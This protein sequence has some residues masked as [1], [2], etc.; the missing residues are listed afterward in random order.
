[1]LNSNKLTAHSVVFATVLLLGLLFAA[2][3]GDSVAAGRY[4]YLAAFVFI[5]AGFPLLLK[6]GTNIWILPLLGIA[7]T[8]RSPLIPLPFHVGELLTMAGLLGFGLQVVMRRVKLQ[9]AWQLVDYLAVANICWLVVTYIKNPVGIA[10]LGSDMVGGRKY[11]SLFFAFFGYYIL[12]R[13]RLP[14]SWAYRLPIILAITWALPHG[15]EAVAL[16]SPELGSIISKFYAI[17]YVDQG[18]AEQSSSLGAESRVLGLEK[19]TLPLFLA[20]CAYYPPIT[21]LSPMNP[22]RAVGF[23]C[24]LILTGLA[25]YRTYILAII[26]YI[27]VNLWLRRRLHD[28]IPFAAIAILGVFV[29]AGA[30]QSGMEVPLTVQRALAFLPLDWDTEAANNAQSTTDWR[31]NMWR[32]AWNDPNYF[33]D[34]V[35]GDGFGYTYQEMI[36]FAN[37]M[38]GLQG[39]TTGATYEM[40]IIR[41]SL[42]NGPLSSLRFGGF[43]GLVLLTALMI[44]SANYAFNVVKASTGTLYK[45]I[46]LFTAIPLIYEPFAFYFIF[47][48]YDNHMIQYFYGLGMLNLINRSL[49]SPVGSVVPTLMKHTT[50]PADSYLSKAPIPA[51]SQH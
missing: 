45:P 16:L 27:T 30:V 51:A 1:M 13:S 41:G 46:A 14:A 22:F 33:K 39:L 4:A 23:L 21:L 6:F 29:L 12:S 9:C 40:F 25:G 5:V 24:C 49:P 34:K 20:M 11:I 36:L 44:A 26:G 15:M 35:F 10:F 28:I 31:L 48:A 17:Q 32:D 37:Q 47:G 50:A 38:Q 2:A 3:V 19:M 18:L 43:V 7:W 42:H 8:Q